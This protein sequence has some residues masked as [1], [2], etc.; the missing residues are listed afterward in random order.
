[1]FW[2]SKD[3]GCG[4]LKV[5]KIHNKT[6][7]SESYLGGGTIDRFYNLQPSCNSA[8][9]INIQVDKGYT[10]QY[11][12]V[13]NSKSYSGEFTLNCDGTCVAVEVK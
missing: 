10:Y 11:T 3:L 5:S 12:I 6:T 1:M 13:C 2:I 9:T 7:A 8:G 4:T